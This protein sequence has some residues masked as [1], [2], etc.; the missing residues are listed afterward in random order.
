[1]ECLITSGEFDAVLDLTTSEIADQMVTG[2]MSAGPNRLETA[3][4]ADVPYILS[5]GA[6]DM[7]NF[8]PCSTLPGRFA[9][10]D[11]NI[12]EHNLFVTLMR[13]DVEECKQKGLPI[14]SKLKKFS[15]ARSLMQV[16]LP[17]GG[18]STISNPGCPDQERGADDTLSL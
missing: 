1:M 16:V 12:N 13:T 14:A 8:G 7:V 3:A 18:V 10:G 2:V 11:R 9:K 4:K 15:L 6:S 17:T 5:V